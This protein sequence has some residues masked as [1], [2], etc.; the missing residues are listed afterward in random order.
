MCAAS[1]GRLD[2]ARR[3]FP[4]AAAR[5]TRAGR[6]GRCAAVMFGDMSAYSEALA[7]QDALPRTG[8]IPWEIGKVYNALLEAAKQEKPDSISLGALDPLQ[9]NAVGFAGNV[10]A[11]SLRTMVAVVAA[12]LKPPPPGA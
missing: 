6:R 7:L 5:R 11:E 3:R 8:P 10:T 2:W 1:A 4:T 9:R 12:A